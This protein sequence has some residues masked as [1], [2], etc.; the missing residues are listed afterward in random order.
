MQPYFFPYA[1]Q[2]RHVAQC[3][4][5]IMFDTV[6]FSRKSWMNRNRIADRNSK[7]SYISV[8]VAKGGSSGTIAEAPLATRDWR[9]ELRNK[10]RVYDRAAPHYAETMAVIERC[11]EPDHATLG[12]LNAHVMITICSACEITTPIERLSQMDMDLPST[13]DP[14]DWA[15]LISQAVGADIYSNAPGGRHLF[16]PDRYTQNGIE[17]EFYRPAPLIYETPGLPFT[18]DLS[19]IDTLMWTGCAS[20]AQ[21]VHI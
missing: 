18:P 11:L 21:F 2:F 14:G 19:V 12:D 4:R 17:L 5:W 20:M 7:W 8:P 10:L 16:D 15:M 13:A 3:D 6:K 1:Q 9:S